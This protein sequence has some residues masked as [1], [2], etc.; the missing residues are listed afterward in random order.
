M[1]ILL[2]LLKS[3]TNNN[4]YYLVYNAQWTRTVA[5]LREVMEASFIVVI[6]YLDLTGPWLMTFIFIEKTHWFWITGFWF[7]FFC[8]E[9]LFD[10]NELIGSF[11]AKKL[12]DNKFI[13]LG[14][15]ISGIFLF[16]Q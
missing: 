12:F 3:L 15:L 2:F 16:S 4:L 7:L 10:V 8:I 1:L 14:T 5:V 9:T 13:L 11:E 6:C